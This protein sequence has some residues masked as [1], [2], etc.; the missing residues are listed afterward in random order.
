MKKT[1]SITLFLALIT[2]ILIF[3][4]QITKWLILTNQDKIYSITG[5]FFQFQ[6][7]EN[8]GIAFGIPIRQDILIIITIVLLLFVIYLYTREFKIEKKLS[9]TTAVLVLAGGLGNLIDRVFRGYV[10][11]F[12]SIWK[13]PD[14]NIADI[15]ITVGVLLMIVFYGKIKR[16]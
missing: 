2:S 6:Y 16:A 14:F 11:D 7:S 15:Y 5:D 4:D 9:Q 8:T 12:I 1:T 10:I 3:F 13:Y